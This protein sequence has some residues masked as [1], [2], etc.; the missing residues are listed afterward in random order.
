MATQFGPV[1]A[2]TEVMAALS[3]LVSCFGT[4]FS[5]A[6]QCLCSHANLSGTRIG[7][8]LTYFSNHY[9]QCAVFFQ[10]LVN[11]KGFPYPT[12]AALPSIRAYATLYEIV[13]TTKISGHRKVTLV[14]RQ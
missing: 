3:T 10:S 6:H 5:F 1:V 13:G 2:D 4:F 12:N 7:F 8:V 14:I 11:L 9:I